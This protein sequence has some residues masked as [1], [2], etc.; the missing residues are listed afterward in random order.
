MIAYFS[1][2]VK[3]IN[4]QPLNKNRRKKIT[5]GESNSD[6]YATFLIGHL[7]KDDSVK[8]K[9]GKHILDLALLV[10][11]AAQNLVGGRLV[12]LDCKDTIE[13][14]NFYESNGFTYFNT[15]QVSQL[16]QYYKIL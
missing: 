16:L 14:K 15:S 3:S 1:V 6:N 13:L 10:I 7:A 11:Y 2:A 5:A 8:Y 4:L 12:Y 9:L